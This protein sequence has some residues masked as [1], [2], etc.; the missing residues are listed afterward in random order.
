MTNSKETPGL[1]ASMIN[2]KPEY[3]DLLH[4]YAVKRY[5]SFWNEIRE[6]FP[7]EQLTVEDIK[8]Y[9]SEEEQFEFN[10]CST[11]IVEWLVKCRKDSSEASL[12]VYPYSKD[13]YYSMSRFKA[14]LK[15]AL[16]RKR[17]KARQEAQ[18]QRHFAALE[19]IDPPLADAEKYLTPEERQR[20]FDS[21]PGAINAYLDR[22]K[23][24]ES[25]SPDI[26]LLT[27]K[28]SDY[29]HWVRVI[30]ERQ[31]EEIRQ[32][33]A[34]I[35][36]DQY[37]DRL[38]ATV[39]KVKAVLDKSKKPELV[40]P[41]A[42]EKYG[43]DGW[44]ELDIP[45]KEQIQ[46]WAERK[47]LEVLPEILADLTR[48][49]LTKEVR[50]MPRA[51]YEVEA[52]I[53][54]LTWYFESHILVTASLEL[55]KC[56]IRERCDPGYTVE[57]QAEGDQL[58]VLY[59]EQPEW[60]TP[61]SFTTPLALLRLI[62]SGE[63]EAPGITV[64]EC[65]SPFTTFAVQGFEEEVE[66]CDDFRRF[67]EDITKQKPLAEALLDAGVI[68][69]YTSS[70]VKLKWDQPLPMTSES[71]GGGS[72]LESVV[73]KL[74]EVGLTESEAKEKVEGTIFP[75]GATV[76]QMVQIILQKS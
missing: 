13:P 36:H 63:L 2:L 68:N 43:P 50:V 35:E 16:E 6:K 10:T 51:A 14:A 58:G 1:L 52:G 76:E 57:V 9:L 59:L 53:P 55:K 40:H 34:E 44:C 31:N 18:K 20:F 48:W 56:V 42:L 39:E 8:L 71:G 22:D 41:L 61:G 67:I 29:S 30:E 17:E 64:T 33:Q 75:D 7:Q 15:T 45:D 24:A 28:A 65:S 66:L 38:S 73:T 11:E 62:A 23:R 70:L 74:V 26:W 32:K 21:I 37:L 3:E 12:V 54:C 69:A 27:S 49:E 46:N 60:L 4:P 5:L 72:K 47:I 19:E 25:Y